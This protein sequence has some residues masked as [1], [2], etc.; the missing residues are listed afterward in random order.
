MCAINEN[1]IISTG[2]EVRCKKKSFLGRRRCDAELQGS[3]VL[4]IPAVTVAV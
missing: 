4:I 3:M 1:R 2:V